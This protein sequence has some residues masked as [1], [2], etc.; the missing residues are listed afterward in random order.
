MLSALPAIRAPPSVIPPRRVRPGKLVL[1]GICFAVTAQ[2][3][4]MQLHKEMHSVQFAPLDIFVLTHGMNRHR[5]HPV[6]FLMR[7]RCSA[8]TAA[9]AFSP[10]KKSQ[11]FVILAQQVIIACPIRS[12]RYLVDQELLVSADNTNATPVPLEQ[13]PPLFLIVWSWLAQEVTRLQEMID[14][15]HV[16]QVMNVQ[17]QQTQLF[18][19][20]DG[21]AF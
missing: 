3:V 11:L 1:E 7:V 14:V 8:T 20:W 18:V 5:V 6:S 4:S 19:L 13:Q 9:L 12:I 21:L 16:R 15:L 10:K 17:I 2:V